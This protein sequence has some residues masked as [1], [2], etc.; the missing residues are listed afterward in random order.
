[1]KYRPD[2]D[3]L[4]AI[5]VLLVLFHHLDVAGMSGGYVGVDVF[6]VISGFLITR[7]I[8]SEIR[9]GRFTLAG[10]YVRRVRRILPVLGVVVAA[11]TAA[12]AFLVPVSQ[13]EEMAGSVV[14]VAL[15]VSNVFFWRHTDYFS[16][17]A[18][19]K[20]LL[21]MW[22]LSVEEQYYLL[23]PLFMVAVRR[24]STRR[25]VAAL[26]V[27]TALSLAICVSLSQS[28]PV[29]AFYLA[30]ARAWELLLGGLLAVQTFPA[31]SSRLVGSVLSTLGLVMVFSSAFLL[32]RSSVFPGWNALSPCVG[33]L[34]I[35]HGGS[36]GGTTVGWLLSVPAVRYIGRISYSLYLWH[37][38]ALVVVR[39]NVVGELTVGHKLLVL[40]TTFLLSAL[41]YR[42]VETPFRRGVLITEANFRRVAL[43]STLGMLLVGGAL[44]GYF[45]SSGYNEQR[46]I[47]ETQTAHLETIESCFR[48]PPSP[49]SLA[50][51]SFGSLE[52]TR[53]FLLWGD[54]HGSAVLPA[55][56]AFARENGWRGIQAVSEGCPPLFDVFRR[57]AP[58]RRLGMCD[59][60]FGHNV[61]AYLEEHRVDA[62]VL[63]AR[64][65][66]Y[67]RG[68]VKN[69][70]LQEGT[71][72]LSDE[73]T[74]GADAASSAIV[75]ERAI[76]RSTRELTEDLGIP[77]IVVAQAPELPRAPNATRLQS[78]PVLRTTY[79]AQQA[80]ANAVFHELDSNERV[81]FLDPVDVFCDRRECPTVDAGIPMYQDD[82][83]LSY[84]GAMRL[85]PLLP[86]MFR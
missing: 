54:S 5:A 24:L 68:W 27:L 73:T 77:V 74:E 80:F 22:S 41:S 23:F 6:F 7:I 49:A 12:A 48:T 16:V 71:H 84:W 28:H 42:Y 55:F 33:T 65:S 2:V 60:Q 46:R 47:A 1:M 3:G 11:T 36:V 63:V 25:L 15:F 53:T 29:A 82:N 78:D 10:F 18:D 66:L 30:H 20:P 76:R 44:Y 34:L 40:A 59:G 45:A 31:P 75:L 17:A 9:E 85:Q 4:R 13:L 70:R 86:A 62:V 81:R 64:W 72:F 79:L 67:E 38:P 35:I 43:G 39:S 57:D 61:R 83:H 8:H 58:A 37:W 51:C 69:G 26:G 14:A 19:L 52:A 56:E 21:H 50:A 32:T